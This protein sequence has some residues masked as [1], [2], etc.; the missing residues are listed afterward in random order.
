MTAKEDLFTPIHKA[1]RSMLYHLSGRLQTHDFADV[2]ATTALMTDLETDF[3]IARSAGCVLCVLHRHADDEETAIFGSVSPKNPGFVQAL[4]EEHHEL[5][6]RELG[7]TKSGREILAMPT[8]EERVRAGVRLNQA[9]ND[10]LALYLAH[11]N[12]EEVDL[13]PL[14]REHFTDAEMAGMRGRIMAGTPPERLAGV[15]GWMLPSLNVNELSELLGGLTRGAPPELV[16]TV[17]GIASAKVDP[18]RW[19]AVR[20]RVGI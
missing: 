5:T 15:L 19:A 12:R 14:M 1:L 2:A 7:I 6:R 17:V 4:I 10:L 3:A 20:S 11:M 8:P 13:V 18:A 16:K 9:L